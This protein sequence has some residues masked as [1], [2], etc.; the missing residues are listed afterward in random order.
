MSFALLVCSAVQFIIIIISSLLLYSRFWHP[1]S[2][3]SSLSVLS[4]PFECNIAN[5]CHHLQSHVAFEFSFLFLAMFC[6]HC[7]TGWSYVCLFV[8]GPLSIYLSIHLSVCP[9]VC[10]SVCLPVCLSMC[11]SFLQPLDGCV[12]VCVSVWLVVCSSVGFRRCLS[13]SLKFSLTQGTC[14]ISK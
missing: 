12:C 5:I 10:L 4:C 6:W 14:H 3:S 13:S 8:G 11:L 1:F 2:V 7:I 9:S